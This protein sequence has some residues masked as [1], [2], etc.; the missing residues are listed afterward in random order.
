MKLPMDYVK[1][2]PCNSKQIF[3]V[4][5]KSYFHLSFYLPPAV[6]S[7]HNMVFFQ[8]YSQ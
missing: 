8:K 6:L 2:I 7:F 4:T 5:A 3:E 1:D